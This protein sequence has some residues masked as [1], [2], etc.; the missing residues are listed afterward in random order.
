M[1]LKN[2]HQREIIETGGHFKK[3]VLLYSLLFSK[4]VNQIGASKWRPTC[5][6]AKPELLVLEDIHDYNH[7]LAR[8]SFSELH[9][10]ESLK[11]L[12][13]MHSACFEFEE[14][15]N[16]NLDEKF[17]DVFQETITRDNPWLLSGFSSVKAVALNN[18]KFKDIFDKINENIISEFNKIF[19]VLEPSSE[20][21]NILCHRDLWGNNIFFKENSEGIPQHCILLDFQLAKYN[22]PAL[23]FIN[24][25]HFNT[26]RQHRDKNWLKYQQ[27]YY[28]QLIKEGSK[29]GVDISKKVSWEDFIKSC[30]SYKIFPLII[31][32]IFVPLTQLPNG[33]LNDLENKDVKKYQSLLN[34]NRDEFIIDFMK[35]DQFYAEYV[36]K[37]VEELVEE[38]F[39]K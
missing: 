14:S 10:I 13:R 11:G 22:P 30:E 37:V 32:C 29:L 7:V 39:L 2:E 35:N 3:E 31:N 21:K 18:P 12:A 24:C 26:R 19:D 34:V 16:M 1:P 25:V 20:F 28:S 17:K 36:N 33:F 4:M 6:L 9:V 5:Y 27:I 8:T 15:L 38:I 23:D